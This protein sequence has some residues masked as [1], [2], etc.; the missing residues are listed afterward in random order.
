[1][2]A[3][4]GW[5]S[6]GSL[7]PDEDS[8]PCVHRPEELSRDEAVPE[9]SEMTFDQFM[10]GMKAAGMDFPV[11]DLDEL[12]EHCLDGVLAGDFVIML[13]REGMEEQLVERAR[14]LARGECPVVA[15]PGMG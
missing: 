10:T 12:A 13:G 14:K 11:Q 3:C 5:G 4:L 9:G 6:S 7:I 8:I 2:I 1:M 15:H